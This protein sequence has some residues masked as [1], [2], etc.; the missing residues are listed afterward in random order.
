MIQQSPPLHISTW[1]FS[2]PNR[3]TPQDHISTW[4]YDQINF[5]PKKAH[6]HVETFFSPKP[7]AANQLIREKYT[8]YLPHASWSVSWTFQREHNCSKQRTDG[9]CL[10]HPDTPSEPW[11]VFVLRGSSG[12]FLRC[13]PWKIQGRWSLICICSPQ[14]HLINLFKQSKVKQLDEVE[15]LRTTYTSL[16]AKNQLPTAIGWPPFRKSTWFYQ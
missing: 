13:H 2:L 16:S 12:S 6:K 4:N 9:K 3:G 5:M 14:P 11:K 1:R 8:Q 15:I 7:Q 10:L